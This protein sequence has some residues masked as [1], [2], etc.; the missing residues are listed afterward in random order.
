METFQLWLGGKGCYP[1]NFLRSL[2]S[3]PTGPFGELEELQYRYFEQTSVKCLQHNNVHFFKTKFTTRIQVLNFKTF[4]Y[5]TIMLKFM[6]CLWINATQ[7]IFCLDALWNASKWKESY[8]LE[9]KEREKG[10]RNRQN[11]TTGVVGSL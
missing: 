4:S 9:N 6:P 10:T 2:Q 11:K 8:K 7:N 1:S 3:L 5:C